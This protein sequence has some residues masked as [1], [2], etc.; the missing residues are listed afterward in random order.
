MRIQSTY[1]PVSCVLAVV[2]WDGRRDLIYNLSTPLSGIG[3]RENGSG[4]PWIG[5]VST[6]Y[7]QLILLGESFPMMIR[8]VCFDPFRILMSDWLFD[9]C[10]FFVAILP[11]APARAYACGNE[12]TKEEGRHACI[13]NMHHERVFCRGIDA[14]GHQRRLIFSTPTEDPADKSFIRS[15]FAGRLINPQVE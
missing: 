6:R 2:V 13:L 7:Q 4:D 14:R 8:L 1:I 11:A 3:N 5:H 9:V 12:A 10:S 15:A